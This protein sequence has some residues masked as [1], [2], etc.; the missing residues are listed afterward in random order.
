MNPE[1]VPEEDPTPADLVRQNLHE[2]AQKAG[3][4]NI[5]AVEAKD[6]N[7]SFNMM[8]YSIVE[9][10]KETGHTFEELLDI[11]VPPTEEEKAS[12]IPLDKDSDIGDRVV[13]SLQFAESHPELAVSA[14]EP[15]E[16]LSIKTI[17]EER[18]LI[19]PEND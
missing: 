8:M 19:P 17:M 16:V 12:R 13:R 18:G 5:H 11:V 6:P 3:F 15:A 7:L 4:E 2:K 9:V 10:A 1:L 14:E